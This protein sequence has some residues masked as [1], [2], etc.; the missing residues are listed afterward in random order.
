ME[1]IPVRFNSVLNLPLIG[2]DPALDSYDHLL[3][4]DAI[5]VRL[6]AQCQYECAFCEREAW[7]N[8]DKDQE[9]DMPVEVWN[10]VRD[11]WL[12]HVIG[13][14]IAGL[15]EPTL[16]PLFPQVCQDVIAAGKV[17]YFP[18]NGV[19]LGSQPILNAVG[20]KP[21]VSVSLD[22]W[23]AESYQ[24]VRGGDWDKVVKS[25]RKFRKAKPNAFLH[26]QFTAGTYNIDGFPQFVHFLVDEGFNEGLLRFVQNH[27]TAREDVSLRF[28]KDRTEKAIYEAQ[29][30]AE[31][32]AFNLKVE[33]RPYSEFV[34]QS[35]GDN[36]PTAKLA[37]Y[38]DFVPMQA[39]ACPSNCTTSTVKSSTTS[40]SNPMNGAYPSTYIWTTYSSY[41]ICTDSI[42]YC[43]TYVNYINM[44]DSQALVGDAKWA[45]TYQSL[46]TSIVCVNNYAT[47]TVSGS[48]IL[49]T[50]CTTTTASIVEASSTTTNSTTPMTLPALT[51]LTLALSTTCITATGI[52]PQ[53]YTT[54]NITYPTLIYRWI[55][56]G[57]TSTGFTT[58]Y[59]LLDTI[60]TCSVVTSNNGTT[61][62]NRT[63]IGGM[64]DEGSGGPQILTSV[65]AVKSVVQPRG[66]EFEAMSVPSEKSVVGTPASIIAW[67]DGK[68]TSCFAQHEVGNVLLNSY[69]DV[70]RNPRYQA[71]L[72]RRAQM[73]GMQIS[74]E[75][76]C[77]HCARVV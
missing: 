11:K 25:I 36:S 8:G 32:A 1:P 51:T 77:N 22:A 76:W 52:C 50:I 45:E 39:I 21:R 40:T 15:G 26:S 59:T 49:V 33:R 41:V 20:D 2:Q 44:Y 14:E 48:T 66:A 61:F 5:H 31:K 19:S 28:A 29:L 3:S 7:R 70:I 35:A 73:G 69:E 53:P 12:P 13:V 42:G 38:L 58:G 63:C 75:T 60:G 18:T 6:S 34:P 9:R 68:L 16:S 10:A 67:H 71:F 64:D 57:L 27:Q 37:R 30:I 74:D 17:L 56:N 4:P 65:Q 55:C 23:D 54:N 62:G 46:V 24:R 72:H 47:Q 43:V